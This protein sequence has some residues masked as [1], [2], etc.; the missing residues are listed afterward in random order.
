MTASKKTIQAGNITTL[1]SV[2]VI[3]FLCL[4]KTIIGF[5]TGSTVLIADGI[6]SLADLTSDIFTYA[7]IR[8]SHAEPDE[9]HP[10][11]HGKFETFG[12][13]F[14]SLFLAIVALAIGYEAIQDINNPEARPHLGYTAL[15]VAVISVLANEGLYHFCTY[16]GKQVNSPIIMA[17][18][19]HHRTDSLSSIA[20]FIGIG[21]NMYGFL[22]A[23]ALAALAV[24]AFLLKI[25][26]KIGR[27]AFDE[28]VDASVDEKTLYDIQ[29]SIIK[30]SGVIAFHQLRAKRIGGQIFI[31]VHADVPSNISVSE[32]HAIAHSIEDS[33]YWDINHVADITVHI[34]PFDAKQEALPSNL[35]RETLEPL[36]TQ[37][38]KSHIKEATLENIYLHI[39]E[40]GYY[41]D[42]IINA[43]KTT[44]AQIAD[45]KKTLEGEKTPFKSITL[46]IRHL[47]NKKGAI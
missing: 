41:A 1:V 17:N 15:S 2:I 45:L 38:I 24:T 39:L 13:M 30:N 11:G 47:W 26:Y 7:I 8:V 40:E 27:G 36:V 29:T 16:K 35:Y 18:A 31:D 14:I 4:L 10:Y 12:T 34:D 22:I 33:L 20:A 3:I 9:D 5:I 42:I 37:I 28:L 6:H 25:S 46:S 32:G 19:W 43:S 23:D 21:L 44:K